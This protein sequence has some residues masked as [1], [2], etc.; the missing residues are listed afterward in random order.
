MTNSAGGSGLE[1]RFGITG[2]GWQPIGSSKEIFKF[3]AV[4]EADGSYKFQVGFGHCLSDFKKLR[5]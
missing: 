1:W 4:P 3:L 2:I 5:G